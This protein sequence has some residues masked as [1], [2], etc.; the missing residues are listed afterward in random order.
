[1][2]SE[3]FGVPEVMNHSEQKQ[4]QDSQSQEVG[5]EREKHIERMGSDRQEV[6][7]IWIL[8]HSEGEVI[9]RAYA[10]FILTIHP[11]NCPDLKTTDNH[12]YPVPS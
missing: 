12:S 7:T 8:G 1:M 9:C 3:A 6:L 10:P 5:H 2:L 4:S 11:V